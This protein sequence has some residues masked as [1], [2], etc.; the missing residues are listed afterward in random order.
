LIVISTYFFKK[1]NNLTGME[2]TFHIATERE[3]I[4]NCMPRLTVNCAEQRDHE[5]I[6]S[7]NE[8][9]QAMVDAM[10]LIRAGISPEILAYLSEHNR[11][12]QITAL[13]KC[14]Q[15]DVSI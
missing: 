1:V 9:E 10:E 7:L 6:V 15:I 3:R 13:T 4:A 12:K 14:N 8:A 11:I 2:N 5:P